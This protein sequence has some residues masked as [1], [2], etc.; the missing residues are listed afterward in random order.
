MQDRIEKITLPNGV[1]IVF[2][3]L[4][5]V[6]SA[7]VGVWV[8]SGSR[9]ERPSESGVS[10]FIEHM[11]FKGTPRRTAAE[12]AE[13]TDSVGG[14][15][16]AFTTK[17]YTC[18]YARV[19]DS[20]MDQALDALCDLFFNARFDDADVAT[21][22]GV[23]LE[24]ISMYEDSPEDLVMER[25]FAAV[26]RG[27]SVGRPILGRPQVLR[28][29]TG[30]SLK[31]YMKENYGP[32]ETV[33]ALS[34]SFSDKDVEYLKAQFAGMEGKSRRL[35]K[36]VVYRPAFTVRRKAIE[37]NHVEIAF[38]GIP[39]NSPERYAMQLLSSI[40]GGGVSSR[41]FQS[42][43][44]K[45]GLCYSVYTFGAGHEDTGVFGIY[46]ALGRETERQALELISREVRRFASEGVTDAEL[47]RA[48]EQVKA[49]VLMGMESTAAR[50]NHLARS[51][52]YLEKH[53]GEEEIIAAYDAVT[54]E[55]IRALAARTFDFERISLSA[56]GR[57][58]TAEE[59]RQILLS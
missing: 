22:L 4:P 44:E 52:L 13:L 39:F 41:L 42:V 50:M 53:L 33:I 32:K 34:G 20:H 19:L 2:E 57:V 1:R 38:P 14:Q 6:R 10:H 54:P 56:V 37:Q 3:R 24:E 5:Y 31:R 15:L 47:L 35:G 16:N 26:Y 18:F 58:R 12:L 8:K 17:E 27:T 59:Y 30:E 21:E 48:R 28:R 25:L 55:Q 36:P 7:S 40:L 43:R 29:Q 49:N 46:T 9:H 45:E 51:E 11:V 23:I